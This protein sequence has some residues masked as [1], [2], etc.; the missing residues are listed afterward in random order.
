MNSVEA[1]RGELVVLIEAI[2]VRDTA[3]T[4]FQ[5]SPVNAPPPVS[6]QPYI[7]HEKFDP[8][9]LVLG[10]RDL[11]LGTADLPKTDELRDKLQQ[12][13]GL[14]RLRTSE[15]KTATPKAIPKAKG[16]VQTARGTAATPA[17]AA[18]DLPCLNP[19]CDE[20][21]QIQNCEKCK[22]MSIPDLSLEPD[23]S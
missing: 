5:Q 22:N 9:D 8:R 19:G 3:A 12:F 15:N 10:P 18:D 2:E 11:V 1:I 4:V 21:H 17:A 16:R 6:A 7:V 13:R 23:T 20:R 14:A